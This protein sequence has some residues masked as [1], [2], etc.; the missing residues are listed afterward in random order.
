MFVH[1]GCISCRTVHQDRTSFHIRAG[2]F[3][4]GV[5][6]LTRI[7]RLLHVAQPFD[8]PGTPT[9]VKPALFNS[10][11]NVRTVKVFSPGI[12]FFPRRPQF[13]TLYLSLIQ[14]ASLWLTFA[15]AYRLGL[16]TPKKLCRGSLFLVLN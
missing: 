14:D 10:E 5:A 7:F 6:I 1:F 2:L 11:H 12:R 13:L 4:E 3:D 9:M 8:F 16:N 15:M